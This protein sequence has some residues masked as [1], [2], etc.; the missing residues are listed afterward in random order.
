MPHHLF[1]LFHISAN[2]KLA[3][4]SFWPSWPYLAHF[5]P[6]Y[7][8]IMIHQVF[9]PHCR[10]SRTGMA[11]AP[12][13]AT[14]EEE[15]KR[16]NVPHQIII[17]KFQKMKNEKPHRFFSSTFGYLAFLSDAKQVC[18]RRVYPPDI[19]ILGWVEGR[20]RTWGPGTARIS[21]P[22]FALLNLLALKYRPSSSLHFCPRALQC[23][24][25]V[26]G[27]TILHFWCNL[28]L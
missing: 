21:R 3:F 6:L 16:L 18:A 24:T 25:A 15:K 26:V 7:S 28:S 19:T 4:G 17:F 12:R 5:H 23:S 27:G 11:H 14:E 1:K 13:K 10:F 9:T 22:Q 2:Q 8:S 20:Q